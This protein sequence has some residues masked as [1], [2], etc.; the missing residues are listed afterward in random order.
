M[1]RSSVV[2]SCLFLLAVLTTQQVNPNPDYYKIWNDNAILT[3]VI[4]NP[5]FSNLASGLPSSLNPSNAQIWSR[6]KTTLSSAALSNRYEHY[7]YVLNSNQQCTFSCGLRSFLVKV[8]GLLVCQR[9]K[10]SSYWGGITDSN[11]PYT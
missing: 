3:G 6:A 2:F 5:N 4:I 10:T 8:N 1:L 9:D 7:K 11:A